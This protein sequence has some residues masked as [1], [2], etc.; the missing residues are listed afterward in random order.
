MVNINTA[1]TYESLAA[2]QWYNA[3]QLSANNLHNLAN[4]AESIKR[5]LSTLKRLTP[6]DYLNYIVGYYKAGLQKFKNDWQYS[7]LLTHLQAAAKLMQPKSYLEIG[8]RRGR[9]LAVLA[10]ACPKIHIVG[11][12]LWIQ[13]YAGME[14]PGPDFV[15]KEL[16]KLGHKGKLELISGDSSETVPAFF[17]KHPDFYFDLITVDGDHSEEG[18]RIDLENTLPHLKIGGAILLDDITHPQHRYLET[19]WDKIITNNP[20]FSSQ[21]Y[22]ELGYG[23]ACAIRRSF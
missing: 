10:R 23:I 2:A 3:V 19:L 12:D 14:N 6:D 4:T 20:Q 18:A 11:F 16:K 9:S 15:M 21:K 13:N 5:T 8:V 7:D 1:V 22:T 17:Q